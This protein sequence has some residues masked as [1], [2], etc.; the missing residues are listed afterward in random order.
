MGIGWQILWLACGTATIIAA[1]LATRSR[2]ARYLGRVAVGV[3]FIIGGALLYVINLATGADYAGFA[4]PAHFAWVTAAWRAVVAPNQIL[5]I[6]L[7][8]VFEATAGVLA[9]SGARRTPLGYLGVI[10]FY[11]ALWLFGWFETV[12]CV[13]MLAP[14]VLLL[15]AERRNRPR[16]GRPCRGEAADGCRLVGRSLSK[17]A[18]AWA[19]GSEE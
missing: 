16:P 6:G 8:V 4:D 15:R 13:I 17:L 18:V 14:M 2:S 9:I 1:V 10:G 5:F 12:S 3:L 19:E 11:L 7:L